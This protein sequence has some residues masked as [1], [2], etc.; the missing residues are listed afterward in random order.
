MRI[1]FT[2]YVLER[3]SEGYS[4]AIRDALLE[5]ASGTDR[6][7]GKVPI[8]AEIAASLWAAAFESATVS[9]QNT[10]TDSLTPAVLAAI[11][12]GV[13]LDGEVAFEIVVNGDVRLI[14][15]CSWDVLGGD[16]WQYRIELPQP[17]RTITK[18]VPADGVVHIVDGPDP[19]TPWKGR[20]LRQRGKQA[21]TIAALIEAGYGE[22]FA[23]SIGQLIA[24]PQV[25]DNTDDLQDDLNRLKGKLKL[26]EST[27]GNWNMGGASTSRPQQDWG[28]RRIG[29]EPPAQNETI[30]ESV[31]RHLLALR[32]VSVAM[33][34]GSDGT[35][36]RESY[37][38]WLHSHIQPAAKLVAAE[39]SAKLEVDGLALSFDAL[40]AADIAG[41]AR[42]FQS[43]VGGG[44][45]LQDAVANSGLLVRDD[46]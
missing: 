2:N 34:G 38:Q 33:L 3:R 41:R 11:G 15:A 8:A 13:C 10:V 36:A 22:E 39:L 14:Q 27:G 18:T 25:G 12:R 45:S 19:A 7:K 21:V 17:Q 35:F 31:N 9:P 43:M 6:A 26:V 16:T 5:E 32:G 24:L 42:A 20:G 1:P 46:E 44:M 4:D 28:S 37:R 29:P 23:L 40:G 30:Y